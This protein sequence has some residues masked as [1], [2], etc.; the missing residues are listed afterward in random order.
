MAV[1][2]LVVYDQN[3]GMRVDVMLVLTDEG[4]AVVAQTSDLGGRCC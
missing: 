2:R 4:F 1:C 3:V